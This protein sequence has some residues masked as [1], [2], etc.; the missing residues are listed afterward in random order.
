MW[1]LQYF[2]T[3]FI[4]KTVVCVACSRRKLHKAFYD[5]RKGQFDISKVP[6]IY[7]SAKYDAIHNA[8]LGLT[9]K[10]LYTV[11]TLCLQSKA[12]TVHTYDVMYTTHLCLA[13]YPKPFV[14][15]LHASPPDSSTACQEMLS[16]FIFSAV[17]CFQSCS[18][19]PADS[20]RDP[21]ALAITLPIGW[22]HALVPR[23]VYCLPPAR[24]RP[25]RCMI[26]TS[27]QQK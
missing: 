5:E 17:P 13:Q 27:L 1:Q 10:P 8:E 15:A 11:S 20:S 21:T 22:H 18:A 25:R 4:A 26:S 12:V 7:D 24:R 16:H 2:S 23:V 3:D 19:P 6:D 9:L 14:S